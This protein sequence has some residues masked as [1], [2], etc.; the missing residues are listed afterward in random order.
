M[1]ILRPQPG[2]LE[3]ELYQA[4]K[5]APEGAVDP[6]KLSSNENPY[7]PSPKAIEAFQAAAVNLHR[8]PNTD[9][10]AL[11]EAIA[12]KNGGLDADRIICGT[13]S[14]EVLHLLAQAYVGPGDETVMSQYGF[15]V[16]PIVT[17]AAGG[18]QIVAPETNRI[19]DV[20]AVLAAITEKT[21][22]VFIANPN[23]PTGTMLGGNELRRLAAGVPQSAL[24]VL[25]GAYAEFAE[26]YDAGLSLVDEFPN[27]FVTRTFSKLYGLGGLRVGWGYGR[28]EIIDVLNRIRG[29]FNL[30]EGQMAAAI[31]AL[32]DA[33]HVEKSVSENAR[34]RVWLREALAAIGV[35]SDPS[36][37]NFLLARF[38]SPELANG[39]D[40]QLQA[41]G[42]IVRR[43]GGYGL[44]NCLRITIG[45]EAGCQ[46]VVRSIATYMASAEAKA[47][48]TFKEPQA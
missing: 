24:L 42:V 22:L 27:V 30:G 31:A 44:P 34:L 47:A 40:A 23:N 1:S 5:S 8:Y 20:D 19:T 6:L 25:D 21:R 36:H 28:R 7:G 14:D 46:R 41:D 15:S 29:P 33:E 12:E 48:A 13:G 11:R 9:H 37:A 3:I 2:I 45:D 18:T 35:P 43:V 10:R 38:A 39:A 26:D 16:Y 32:N 4:G 17:Q